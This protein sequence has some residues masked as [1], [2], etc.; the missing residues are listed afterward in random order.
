MNVEEKTK[1]VRFAVYEVKDTL[2]EVMDGLKEGFKGN[3]K[4]LEGLKK[5]DV[6]VKDLQRV[7]TDL[8][9][10]RRS[11]MNEELKTEKEGRE[12]ATS[13]TSPWQA[14]ISEHNARI[15]E[16]G[17]L[18]RAVDDDIQAYLRSKK[19]LR[20]NAQSEGYYGDFDELVNLWA[21]SLEF[22]LKIYNPSESE[23]GVK[24]T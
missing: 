10:K 13:P 15:R 11:E 24:W 9:T 7:G 2:D 17:S 20:E 12:S 18:L 19:N 3:I 4:V 21:Y 16:Y 14:R 22:G 6:A 23:G 1:R 5:V 8:I